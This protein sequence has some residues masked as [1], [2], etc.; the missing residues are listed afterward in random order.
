MNN[1]FHPLTRFPRQ[2]VLLIALAV[3]P[4]LAAAQ[5]S[6]SPPA[7]PAPADRAVLVDPGNGPFM[8]PDMKPRPRPQLKPRMNSDELKL[9]SRPEQRPEM[10]PGMQPNSQKP[11]RNSKPVAR[12]NL[13]QGPAVT[14]D[15]RDSTTRPNSLPPV[16]SVRDMVVLPPAPAASAPAG[17]ASSPVRP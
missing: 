4:L 16:D 3:T 2:T 10:S 15:P 11:L 7:G 9:E 17:T 6:T 5:S 14:V 8:A 12:D 1:P 13:T